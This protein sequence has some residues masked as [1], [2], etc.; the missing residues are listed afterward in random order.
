MTITFT[1][2]TYSVW[3][4]VTKIEE[5][6]YQSSAANLGTSMAWALFACHNPHNHGEE[7]LVRIHMQIPNL[8][9]EFE[10]PHR[11]SLSQLQ[12]GSLVLLHALQILA[13]NMHLLLLANSRGYSQTM[14][15]SPVGTYCT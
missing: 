14:K 6:N 3:T 8:G 11:Q 1:E 13:L 5:D 2:P 7:A 9:T 4:L 10:P 12:K 15:W